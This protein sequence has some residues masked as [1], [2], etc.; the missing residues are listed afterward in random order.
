MQRF[1]VL[2]GFL[3]CLL[4]AKAQ[5]TLPPYKQYTLRDGL[6]QMQVTA[7]F[8][9]SRGYIWVG[10]KAGLN[11]FNGEKFTAYTTKK[12]PEFASDYI[13][14]ICED[15]YGLIWASTPAGIC[16][17]DGDKTRFFKVDANPMPWITADDQGRLWFTHGKY[18]EIEFDIRYIEND[19]IY[20]V[21]IQI[22]KEEWFPHLQIHYLKDE[23]KFLLAKNKLLY[24]FDGNRAEL[25]DKNQTH[26]NLLYHKGNVYYIEGFEPYINENRESRN[27]DVKQYK[28]GK[29]ERLASVRNGQYVGEINIEEPIP[30]AVLALPPI[31]F[32][33]RPDSVDYLSFDKIQGN[34][35]ITDNDNNLWV[36]GE[37]GL[38]Q[39]FGQAFTAYSR[40]YLPQVWAVIEDNKQALWFSSFFYGLTKLENEKL[41]R[42]PNNFIPHAAYP[43]FHPVIDRRGRLFFPDSY[44]MLMYDGKRFEQQSDFFAI[45]TYY[46]K[47]NDLVWAGSRKSAVAFD[48]NR[49]PVRV[50]N[51][52]MKLDVGN[53][54]LTIGKDSSGYYWFGGGIG[55]ARYNWQSNNLKNYKLRKQNT[56]VYTQRNDY[57]GRTW[58]GTKDGLY[59]Y[60]VKTDSLCKIECEELSYVVNMLEPIDSSWLIVSQPYGIY[61]FDL[62]AYYRNGEISLQLFNE[63]NGFL[64]IEPGQDGAFTDSKGNVWMTT[65]TELMKLDPK[66]LKHSANF[67]TVRIDKLNGQK[68]PFTNQTIELPRNQNSAVLI[69]DAICF[70]RPN[71]VQY[72][73]KL[74]SDSVWSAWKEENYVVVSNL[75]D[76]KSEILFR[77]R[78][79]GL[80]GTLATTSLMVKIHV[81]IWKQPWFF[82][83]L[84]G[85][86]A[87]LSLLVFLLFIHTRTK[88]MLTARQSKVFQV[89]AI[90]S[91]MNPHFIFNVLASF[92]TMIL[93]LQTEKANLYLVK[94]AGLIRGF[95]DA[96]SGSVSLQNTIDTEKG[97]SLK[98]ELELIS[99]FVEFQQLI[100]PDKFKY[101]IKI[102]E[103]IDLEKEKIPPMIL[104]PFVENAIRHG[105]LLKNG[106]GTLKIGITRM[107]EK[108]LRIIIE[109]DGVG[110]EKAGKMLTNSP[111][112]YESKGTMLTLNR[113]K[114]LNE[115]GC[116]IT[117]QTD[118]SVKGTKIEITI[119]NNEQRN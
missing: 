89:Q 50:I 79:P 108:G 30:Y 103:A 46:D 3:M 52:N 110:I 91:Q 33:L 94:L 31:I 88:M 5:H 96:S 23:K 10:T 2:I 114:L 64:G 102:D 90:Q 51:E 18:P 21:P 69:F 111:F 19:S 83:T 58:F 53:N 76:G 59:W 8:Q 29:I 119:L 109:D 20:T 17:I 113:I 57:K 27:F 70:N 74:A 40:E 80:P 85:L 38:Y 7:M 112:R 56:G 118:S 55:L 87:L 63:K 28:S 25:I 104:Q 47:E 71:A 66:K 67:L 75:S 37:E 105:L 41:T 95:L 24:K 99:G 45:C 1:L 100:Y 68:L 92:Q 26:V 15:S 11:C 116:K 9:D 65:S 77:A 81:A 35:V 82:P 34:K 115:L 117:I 72:S 22:P 107:E 54:V 93:S 60:D 73:W 86:F 12:Y 13:Y 32:I 61:L 49:K 84:F 48:A 78:V 62:Q 106:Y 97:Q 6:S 98:K 16:R 42:Y 36:G 43:Y 4:W 39:L 14:Q 44:G 101:I